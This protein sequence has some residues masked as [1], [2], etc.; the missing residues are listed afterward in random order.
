MLEAPYIHPECNQS[1]VFLQDMGIHLPSQVVLAMQEDHRHYHTLNHI[2]DILRNIPQFAE[3][4]GLNDHQ[5]AQL[6]ILTW[7]HDSVYQIGSDLVNE[8]E[9]ARLFRAHSQACDLFFDVITDAMLEFAIRDTR[10]HTNP[11]TFISAVFM[12]LDLAGLGY[13]TTL[14]IDNSDRVKAEYI[15]AYTDDEW[16]EGRK[17][18]LTAFLDRPCIYHTSLGEKMWGRKA[19]KNMQEELFYVEGRIQGQV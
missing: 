12:D 15:Q 10:T 9:S 7:Y 5:V 11:S 18:F 14:Y 19:R 1:I 8:D 3:T 4:Y 13:E 17:K 2:E 6:H 16:L